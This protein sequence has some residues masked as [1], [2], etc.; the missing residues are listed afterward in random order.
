MA[1][2][3]QLLQALLQ[4]VADQEI[5]TDEHVVVDSVVGNSVKVHKV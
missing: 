2:I 1:R 4:A 5:T 3:H